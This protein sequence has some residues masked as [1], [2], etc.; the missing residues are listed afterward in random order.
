MNGAPG[1][2]LL[3][4]TTTRGARRPGFAALA[5]GLAVLVTLAGCGT[6]DAVA[7][8]SSDAA[9]DTLY[10]GGDVVTVEDSLP[11]AEALA[12]KDGKILAVGPRAELEARHMG[13]DTLVVDLCGRA[14][15][16]GFIDAHG[17]YSSSLSV[18]SQANVYAPPAGP[19]EDVESIVAT[20]VRFRE[21]R[22]IA[23][24]E[25]IQA[26]GYDD[27][28]MPDGRLLNRDDLDAAFPDHPLI[29]HHVSMHGAVLNSAALTRFG[30][31]AQTQT[32]PGGVIIRK[33]GTQEPYGLLMETAFLPILGALPKPTPEEEIENTRAGQLLYA[34]HGITTAQ[35]GGTHAADLDVMKRGASAGAHLID[36]VAF[37]LIIDLDLIVEK[38][39]VETWGRYDNGLK[40]GG[41]K[42]V[43]DG[44]PQ[45]RTALF[46]TPYL[47]GGPGG[48]QDWHGEPSFPRDTLEKM[49]LRVRELNVPLNYHANGDA[50]IDMLLDALDKATGGTPDPDWRVT[51]I[52][53]QF[54]RNE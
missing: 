36:V 1:G 26:Y 46:T 50:A 51:L 18:A 38:Y 3:D 31:S 25:L 13:A 34:Q 47:A 21:E 27:T 5:S 16:P 40:I 12:V 7:P 42:V 6:R 15:L 37:P 23:E 44:S 22:Q 49:V 19:G 20:I 45:G 35:E 32:P 8:V 10:V 4:R 29:V 43:G 39:P 33:P 24:G 11:V 53:G 28:R 52:H 41:V 48:E 9:A 30:I 2:I 54:V 17:H 14:L